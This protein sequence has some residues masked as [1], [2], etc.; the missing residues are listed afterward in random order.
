MDEANCE[1]QSNLIDPLHKIVHINLRRC[2]R[3][4]DEYIH[5]H[6]TFLQSDIWCQ[7]KAK[8][9]CML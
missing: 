8:E 3:G 6:V 2:T 9:N 7:S 1:N 5:V 4:I